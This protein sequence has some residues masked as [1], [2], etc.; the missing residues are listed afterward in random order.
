M[1]CSWEMS[2]KANNIFMYWVLGWLGLDSRGGRDLGVVLASIS[3]LEGA[4]GS[5]LS[6]EETADI[7]E[8]SG[9]LVLCRAVAGRGNESSFDCNSISGSEGGD[10][11]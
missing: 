10:T 6:D 3:F 11:A 1:L 5:G 7:R 9:R 8:G 4:F 2:S